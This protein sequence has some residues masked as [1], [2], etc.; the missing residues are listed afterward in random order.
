MKGDSYLGM[1]KCP[2]CGTT[3]QKIFGSK[4][5]EY[6]EC[7]ECG[8]GELVEKDPESLYDYYDEE[9]YDGFEDELEEDYENDA[10]D[11]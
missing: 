9:D 5:D 3:M 2:E 10:L 8:Y 1:L 6:Y 7:I 11:Y 4:H